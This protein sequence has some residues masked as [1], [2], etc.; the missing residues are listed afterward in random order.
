MEQ[1]K[2]GISLIVLIVMILIMAIIAATA[3]FSIKENNPVTE[4]EKTVDKS[5]MLVYKEEYNAYLANQYKKYPNFN[6]KNINAKAV[7]HREDEEL[8]EDE[9]YIEKEYDENDLNR[10]IPTY[11]YYIYE[12]LLEIINGEIYYRKEKLNEL[13]F[14]SSE[15][16]MKEVYNFFDS[17]FKDINIIKSPEVTGN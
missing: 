8:D 16:E 15:E 1:N 9:G 12:D 13:Y 17:N 10:Y 5:N 4:A 11:K 2:K 14:D 6:K 7:Y 3:I